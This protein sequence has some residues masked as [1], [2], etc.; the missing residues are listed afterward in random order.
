[1]D[2]KLI[3]IDNGNSFPHIGVFHSMD[4]EKQGPILFN[5]DN[6]LRSE[7]YRNISSY[8]VV[9]SDV[10]RPH[11]LIAELSYKLIPIKNYWKQGKFFDMPV[12]YQ[13]T[14]GED[15]LY[16]AFYIFKKRIGTK[17]RI[18]LI[19]SG[20]F[21]TIDI[22]DEQGLQGGLIIPGAKTFLRSYAQAAKLPSLQETT[23][24]L[25]KLSSPDF[26]IPHSTEDAIIQGC[27]LTFLAFYK[28]FFENYGPFDEIILTGGQSNLQKQ[29]LDKSQINFNDE[30]WLIHQSLCFIYLYQQG[31]LM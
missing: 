10:G 18:A 23:T 21:I 20:T 26:S 24:F 31:K 17:K 8:D 14:L 3:T 4:F 5:F 9:L 27:S 15:R 7:Y 28:S 12:N 13:K 19:D 29:L 25:Q 30:P 2:L 22:I 16:Q 6:F 11:S 1:M